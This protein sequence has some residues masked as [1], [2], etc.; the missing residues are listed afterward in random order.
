MSSVCDYQIQPSPHALQTTSCVPI[1]AASVAS[2]FVM[3]TKT[4]WMA[5]MRKIVVRIWKLI[6]VLVIFLDLWS[7][8]VYLMQLV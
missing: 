6:H 4:A 2:M 7:N 5:L 3:E 1:I 8:I